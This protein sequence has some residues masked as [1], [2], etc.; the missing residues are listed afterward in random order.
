ME[1][2]ACRQG[3][4]RPM[5]ISSRTTSNRGLKSVIK[6]SGRP[7]RAWRAVLKWDEGCLKIRLDDDASPEFWCEI[8]IDR[9]EF[10]RMEADA[11]LKQQQ[12]A[13]NTAIEA[14]KARGMKD[15]GRELPGAGSNGKQ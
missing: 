6:I 5:P 3:G 7:A 11:W 8:V 4:A 12:T 1:A 15:T 13:Y 14:L 10:A 9:E 2:L